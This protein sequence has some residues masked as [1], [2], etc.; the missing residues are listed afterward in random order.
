M[1]T[2]NSLIGS[3]TL[4]QKGNFLNAL[5]LRRKNPSTWIVNSGTSEHMTGDASSFHKYN[6]CYDNFTVRIADRSLSK[7]AG[8]GSVVISKNL[9]LDS[10]LLVPNLDC[11][12]LSVGKLTHEK[13]CL[14]KFFPNNCE[15]QDLDLGK[16][17]GSAEV[18][19]RLY[20]LKVSDYPEEQPQK[21]GC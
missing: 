17:I 18:C 15:F 5:N 16:M 20:I 8:T 19:L 4:A 6:P 21:A 2:S 13:N 9:T 14:T 7:V 10:L 3:G 12:L 11:N 1:T